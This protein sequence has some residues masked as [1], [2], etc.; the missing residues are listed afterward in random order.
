MVIHDDNNKIWLK[1]SEAEALSTASRIPSG[2]PK[3]PL[4]WWPSMD[5][6]AVITDQAAIRPLAVGKSS[7]W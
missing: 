3:R 2:T 7:V 1:L 5:V 4:P 6:S